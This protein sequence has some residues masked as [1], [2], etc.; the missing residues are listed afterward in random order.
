MFGKPVASFQNTNFELAACQAEVDAAQA[1]ADRAP[2]SRRARFPPCFRRH[3][4]EHRTR[5]D[6]LVSA[7]LGQPIPVGAGEHVAGGDRH[8]EFGSNGGRGGGVV[9][10][11]QAHGD[12]A[13]GQA[14][15]QPCGIGTGRVGDAE[16]ADRSQ[17]APA[18]GVELGSEAFVFGHTRIDAGPGEIVVRV[19][20]RNPPDKDQ[21]I[22]VRVD[23]EH[24]HTCSPPPE[25]NA[26][27]AD[28][29][30]GSPTASRASTRPAQRRAQ[31][32]G[33]TARW[34][35]TAADGGIDPH[36]TTRRYHGTPSRKGIRTGVNE[37]D[38]KGPQ[39]GL[40]IDV[41]GSTI[42]GGV[43]D[44]RSGRLVGPRRT[45]ATP[46]PATTGAV[47]GV[48]ADIASGFAWQGPVGVAVPAVVTNG[49]TR[50]AANIDR[51]WIEAD[52]ASLCKDR[53][54]ERRVVV[55]NDADAAGIAEH[56]FGSPRRGLVVALT[57]GTGIGSAI[58]HD[59]V[60]VPNSELGQLLITDTRIEH[61]AAASVK[62]RD[63]LD[64]PAWAARVT[65]VLR[66]IEDL[67]PSLV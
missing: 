13:L 52:F 18:Q 8:P 42:K 57:F 40:G 45:E 25:A 63:G 62:N 28:A 6:G 47:A 1:V 32:D 26:S 43:V 46:K 59:G 36:P 65:R 4:R 35:H 14:G 20:W 16:Q 22:R 58:L 7:A 9:A 29:A 24:T 2:S 54:L 60:L 31:P 64:Y 66:H 21:T 56:R 37:Q 67:E 41:G 30:S 49:V 27:P 15:E 11:D 34:V 5:G 39:L 53:L 44:L 61:L 17:P 19:D 23:E 51:S 38:P 50:S 55:I 33:T 3:S 48:I 12:V 10:G